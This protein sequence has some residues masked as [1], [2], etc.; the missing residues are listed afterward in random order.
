MDRS[1]GHSV[2]QVMGKA[3]GDRGWF[4]LK[5]GLTA[6]LDGG[7]PAEERHGSKAGFTEGLGSSR[8]FYRWFIGI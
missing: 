2:E 8:G 1:F 5:V 7:V 4:R 3:K 6:K